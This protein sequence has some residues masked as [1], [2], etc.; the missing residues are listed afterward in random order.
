MTRTMFDSTTPTAIP[1]TAAMVAGYV[2]GIFVWS[3]AAWARF[4]NAVHVR[5]A[6]LASTNDGHVLDVERGDASPAQAPPWVR[7]RRADGADPSV[8]CNLSTWPAVQAAFNAAGV[9]QP[10]YWIAHY[11]AGPG[12]PPGAV[13]V[14]YADPPNGSGGQWDISA[15]ADLWPGVDQGGKVTS[16]D[17][18]E[19]EIISY[20]AGNNRVK[21][22]D[23]NSRNVFDCMY[24][25]A[26]RLI[27]I[28]SALGTHTASPLVG[29]LQSLQPGTSLQQIATALAP[30]LQPLLPAGVAPADVGNALAAQL[31]AI[32][33]SNSTSA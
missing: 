16:P 1:P 5:I 12:I 9:A 26:Q 29:A 24:D 6:V 31:Q 21:M 18:G 25:T 17:L 23:G 3:P 22:P 13:A 14:Q 7:M 8:Y 15:V 19:S 27:E 33:N 32:S 10:H 4:P 30:A 20:L 2:D 28:Q 11:G